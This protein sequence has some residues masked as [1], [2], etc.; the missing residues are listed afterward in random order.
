MQKINAVRQENKVKISAQRK[1]F[2]CILR[3]W[4][5]SAFRNARTN[6]T[7]DKMNKNTSLAANKDVTILLENFLQQLQSILS[8]R[9]VG[10][11]VGGSLA[12]NCF[13]V[14]TSDIDCYIITTGPLSQNTL[15]QIETLHNKLFLSSDQYAKKIE[16]SYIS[17]SDLLDFNIENKRPY[18]NEGRFYL[19]PYGSNFKI[20]LFLLRNKGISIAGPLIQDLIKEISSHDLQRAIKTNLYEYWEVML[21]DL[22]KLSRSDYQVFAIFTMCRTL[23]SLETSNITSKIE[24]ARWVLD[25][26]AGWEDLIV[27]A[28]AWQ[29]SLELNKLYETKQFIQ[30]V[31]DKSQSLK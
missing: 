15:A 12:N 10:L 23:Y 14:A 28:I 16:A 22:A 7:L 13:N 20:E 26:Y 25:K 9:L 30:F 24:A 29:P 2:F 27:Q 4:T 5:K 11:Y 3:A 6:K 17:Q 19:A 8:G 18:F 21:S 1:E 31:L